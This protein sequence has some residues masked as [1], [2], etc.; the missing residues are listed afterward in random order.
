M[1]EKEKTGI[2]YSLIHSWSGWDE[3]G[4]NDLYFYNVK[5]REDVFPK[6]I[7]E[8]VGDQE[9][10]L[11]LSLSASKAEVWPSRRADDNPLYTKH[12]K[13]IFEED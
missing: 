7:I 6:E 10:D 11:C 2:E 5:L 8:Q 13:L 12:L 3:Y 1:T 4:I 9:V